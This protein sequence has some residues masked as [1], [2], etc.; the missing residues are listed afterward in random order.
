MSIHCGLSFLFI[1]LDMGILSK[2]RG[3]SMVNNETIKRMKEEFCNDI[4]GIEK[5]VIDRAYEIVIKKELLRLFGDPE[6]NNQ[7][8]RDDGY[9]YVQLCNELNQLKYP[10]TYLYERWLKKDGDIIDIIAL[11]IL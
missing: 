7:Y 3:V 11:L 8:F 5:S 2:K 9:D 1:V 10:L 6:I 4:T